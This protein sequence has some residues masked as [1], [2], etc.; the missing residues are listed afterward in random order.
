MIECNEKNLGKLDRLFLRLWNHSLVGLRCKTKYVL[1]RLLRLLFKCIRKDIY[2][3]WDV[4]SKPFSLIDCIFISSDRLLVSG[5]DRNIRLVISTSHEN[6]YYR[7]LDHIMSDDTVF[8]DV[9][10]HLGAFSLRVARKCRHG[11][12]VALEPDPR[13]YYYLI[14]NIIMNKL[15]NIIALPIAIYSESDKVLAFKLG[16]LSGNSSL[17]GND[18]DNMNKVK[19]LTKTL[20]DL[21]EILGLEKVNI[22]KIDVEGA[23]YHVL[24][25]AV[26]VLKKYHPVLLLEIHGKKQWEL[27]NR[28]L[29]SLDY[30]IRVIRVSPLFNYHRNTIAYWCNDIKARDVIERLRMGYLE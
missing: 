5:Y 18:T 3:S 16:R 1:N 10:A 7:I 23:E 9:G 14:R 4:F 8:I 2:L 29:S 12:V 11:T 25:G 17:M 20:N 19:V 13:N 15:T 28:L 30:R 6:Y 26:D 22:I 21:V 24:V 27:I